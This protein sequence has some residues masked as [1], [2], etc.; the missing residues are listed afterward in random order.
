LGGLRC[1][2]D[3][4]IPELHVEVASQFFSDQ[5]LLFVQGRLRAEVLPLGDR[6]CKERDL[7]LLFRIDAV[8]LD[9]GH[10]GGGG[11][12]ALGQGASAPGLNS[13][14]L[15][16]AAFDLGQSGDHEVYFRL[17]AVALGVDLPFAH[18]RLRGGTNHVDLHSG[19][20]AID[21]DHRRKADGQDQGREKRTTRV[22]EDIAP[23]EF[24]FDH[25]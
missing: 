12:H 24:E 6:S 16:Q 20:Q 21:E 9:G 19:H 15:S 5:N 11:E 13:R 3:N 22:A 1:R 18:Q 2:Q 25:G 7:G 8:D 14:G 17:I 10:S 23:G 4:P